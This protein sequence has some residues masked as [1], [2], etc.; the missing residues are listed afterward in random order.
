MPIYVTVI[1]RCVISS[2]SFLKGSVQSMWAL[3][4]G[5][6]TPCSLWH[7]RQVPAFLSLFPHLS[8]GD[9]TWL[10]LVLDLIWKFLA[11]SLMWGNQPMTLVL[12]SPSHRDPGRDIFTHRWVPAMCRVMTMANETDMVQVSPECLLHLDP[13]V[14]HCTWYPTQ[15]QVCKILT[16]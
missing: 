6:S 12:L 16:S 15:R 13:L 11:Q 3:E 1:K 14:H 4:P 7:L 2:I 8:N 5:K 9:N 10:I